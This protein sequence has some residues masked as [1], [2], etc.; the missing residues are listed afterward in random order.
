MAHK[1]IG[2]YDYNKKKICD[3]YDSNIQ[4]EGQAYN[5]TH[6]EDIEGRQTLTFTIPYLIDLNMVSDQDAARY[7]IDKYGEGIFSRYDSGER[8]DQ[9]FRWKLLQNEYL[10]RYTNGSRIEWF[11]AT[12]PVKSKTAKAITGT[13]T[14][15]D[16]ASLLKTRNIYMTFDDENGIGTI[17]ELMKKILTGTG[18]SLGHCDILYET[19]TQDEKIRSLSSDGKQGALNLIATVCN[20]FQCRP[21]YRSNEMKVDIYAMNNRQ[22]I[23]EGEVGRNLST[24][25]A[26]YDSTNIVTR[27]YVE[28]EYGEYGYVGIDDIN[29]T[30]LSYLLNFDYFREIG[31]FT[32]AHEA[33]LTNYFRNIKEI[34]EKISES[35]GTSDLYYAQLVAMLGQAKV[36][37]FY[38]DESVIVPHFKYGTMTD[39]QMQL[40]GGDEVLILNENVTYRTEKIINTP[41]SLLQDGDY[42]IA[43]FV[44][45]ASGTIGGKEVLVESKEKAILQYQKKIEAVAGAGHT[46]T[47][48]VNPPGIM[49]KG[50]LWLDISKDPYVIMLFDGEAWIPA[51]STRQQNIVSYYTE[52]VRL[53]QEIVDTYEGVD[54]EENP[55]TGLYELMYS[56]MKPDGLMYQE[57]HAG[58]VLSQLYEIQDNIEAEFI[59]A[60]GYMLRDGYWSNANYTIGQE[61]YLYNDAMDMSAQMARPKVTYRIGYER[62][63]EDFGVPME[64]IQC[65]AILRI[66]DE[67]I[68]VAENTYIKT[69]TYGVDDLSNGSVEISNEDISMT[70]ADLGQLVSRMAQLAD[71]IEQRNSLYERAKA[72]TSDGSLYTDRLSGEINVMRTQ[73]LSTVSNWW[74]D[75]RGNLVFEAADGSGA[76]MLSGA[77][78]MLASARDDDGNWDWR[79]LGTGRGITADEIVA[80]FLSAERIEAGSIT[81]DKVSAEFGRDLDLESNT[82]INLKIVQPIYND[83]NTL[84]G[85]R[86]EVMSTTDILS[87]EVKATTLTARVWHGSQ[88]VT[89]TFDDKYFNWKRTSNNPN[90]D[91]AWNETH[92]GMRSITVTCAEIDYSATYTCELLEDEEDE[93]E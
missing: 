5:I 14:C 93:G 28:G 67:Q 53:K 17:E 30:G 39:D 6:K 41:T 13:C 1:T 47:I 81:T 51:T 16:L 42:A 80:G 70:G 37:V 4:L 9:N 36:A 85:Y 82:S 20:L 50:D 43:K 83:M 22:Q 8:L 12:K 60:M 87:N 40:K 54:D 64:D 3:L 27:L 57:E 69:V 32:D 52:I 72:I 71:L 26:T 58:D 55:V 62:L 24:L 49:S 92:K 63:T 31:V 45:K 33:A 21:V 35:A 15:D 2:I 74:T 59:S 7:G 23:L 91:L 29:P 66:F 48:D 90:A 84:V 38:P 44:V 75:D 19:G 76:M 73:I 65:N 77:G 11:L 86:V 46:I 88:N 18:W 89:S 56:V 34:K 78:Y 25:S 61:Q 10:I 68:K 79:T